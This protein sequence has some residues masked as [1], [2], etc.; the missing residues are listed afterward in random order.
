MQTKDV[1]MSVGTHAKETTGRQTTKVR[2]KQILAKSLVGAF[3]KSSS[4]KNNCLELN[5]LKNTTDLSAVLKEVREETRG[6]AVSDS[7][8]EEEAYTRV[9]ELVLR[10]Y[11]LNQINDES[12]LKRAVKSE[13]DYHKLFEKMLRLH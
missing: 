9:K 11:L 2:Q 3:G 10:T 5:S 4:E 13:G 12:T 8:H 6:A 7:V 1:E